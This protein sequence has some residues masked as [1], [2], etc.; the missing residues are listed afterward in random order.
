VAA[1]APPVLPPQ[2]T[3]GGLAAAVVGLDPLLSAK[4]ILPPVS[5]N[6]EFSRGK[7]EGAPN[8]GSTG[9]QSG[10]PGLAV[11]GGSGHGSAVVTGTDQRA[12]PN[13][14]NEEGAWVAYQQQLLPSGGATLSAPLRPSNRALPAQIEDRFRNRVVYTL[15]IPIENMPDYTGDWIIWFAERG[16]QSGGVAQVRAP[17]PMG[18]RVPVSSQAN[19]SVI[20]GRVRLAATVT[21][22]GRVELTTPVASDDQ[23]LVAGAMEDL[24]RWKFRPATR[25]GK[26]IGVDVVVEI[27][28]RLAVEPT[29]ARAAG[30]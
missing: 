21:D 23:R 18:K 14:S 17:V 13:A 24:G 11:G 27:P 9:G 12:K 1:E 16:E 5:R 22:D 7:S 19:T 28:Y 30:R 29:E 10:L 15:V 8:P 3:Q 6:A 26:T 2:E 20:E 25:N 4:V